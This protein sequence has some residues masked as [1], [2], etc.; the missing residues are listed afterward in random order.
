MPSSNDYRQEYLKYKRKYLKLNNHIGG[1]KENVIYQASSVIFDNGKFIR[2][3]HNS[4]SDTMYQIASCSKFITSLIVAKL[5]EQEKLDYDVDINKYL[6]QWKCPFKGIT[7]RHLLTHTSGSSDRNGYLGMDPQIP[8]IQNLQLNIDIISGKSYS[9]PFNATEKPGKKF[10]YS[11]AGYQ[12]V[13]QVLEEVTNKRLHQL[14]EMH[15]FKPLNMKNSTGKLLYEG[16]HKYKLAAMDGLYRMYP[17]TAA[18][19]VWTSPNDLALLALDIMNGYNNDES[20]IL[21]QSTIHMITKGEHPE[22]QKIYANY[23]LGMFIHEM[24]GKKLFAHGGANYGYKM[25]FYCVPDKKYIEIVMVN[26]NPKYFKKIRDMA[27]KL[28]S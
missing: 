17:E 2:K 12:V 25:D 15:I 7:L 6:K 4:T 5:Y 11:G 19:G 26:H 28:L 24:N 18:A 21:K 10:M 1:E 16:K 3:N 23:G 14:M 8:Y 13:Q 20:K 9:K 27:K 22:W